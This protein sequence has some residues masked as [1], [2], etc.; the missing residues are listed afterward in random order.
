MSRHI[1]GKN[2]NQLSILPISLDDMIDENNPVRVI[3][4]LVESLDMIALGFKHVEP[5]ATGRKPYDSKDL[6]KLY[7]YGYFNGVRSSRKL[8]KECKRNI[9]VMWLINSLTPDDKTIS[10]FRKDN[11]EAMTKVFKQFSLLC[12]E[13][14]LYGKEIIAV[15]G[16]KFRANNSRKKNYTKN[17]VKKMLAYYEEAAKKRIEDLTKMAED[18]EKNGEISITDPDAKHMS[19]SNNGT[20]IA[21]NVQTA[22]DS[23]NHLVVAVDVVSTPADQ[24]QLYNMASKAVEELGIKKDK[25][26]EK[27]EVEEKEIIT[28]LADKGYY[29]GEELKKC[30]EDG[31]RTIVPKQKSGSRTGNEKYIKDNFIY[32]EKKYIYICPNGEILRNISKPTSKKQTY[33]NIEACMKCKD[34]DKCTTAKK[35]RNIVRNPYQE[36][37]DEVDKITLE[38]KK[39]YK[40]R[41]MMVE[42]PFGT[43]KRTLGCSYFLTRGNE[44][45]K[46]ESFIHFLTYNII[47]VINIMGVKELTAILKSKKHI[48]LYTFHNYVKFISI[49]NK[50]VKIVF[51]KTKKT[52]CFYAVCRP[53]NVVNL[54]KILSKTIFK[55]YNYSKL[56]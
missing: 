47:R 32:D 30:K 23:K 45:V 27:E 10:D 40:Q 16:S 31:I 1:K 4:S 2:R 7:L 39:L 17:K 11:K 5:K 25:S 49:N 44:N 6:E 51:K 9:E 56:T 36:T 34:K 53:L 48:F 38:N 28:V 52:G 37:Y 20:D 13:L 29:C 21:H 18:I 46:A 41:Q 26:N 14:G 42:H 55:K 35:S 24:N 8:E 15:D 54:S 3:D 33:K 22:V 12:N 50:Y 19:V 43:V